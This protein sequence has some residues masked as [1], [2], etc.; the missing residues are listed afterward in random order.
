MKELF[1]KYKKHIPNVLTTLRLAAVPAY[2]VLTLTGNLLPA[3]ILFGS[4]CITDALDGYLARKWKV[5]SIYGKVT[6]PLAY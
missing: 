6:D 1:N 5:E 4:A 2:W 3:T